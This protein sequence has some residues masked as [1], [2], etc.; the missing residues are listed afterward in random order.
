MSPCNLDRH[1]G[2]DKPTNAAVGILQVLRRETYTNR[3]N[4]N[5]DE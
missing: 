2:S 5:A 4:E 3:T 1:V